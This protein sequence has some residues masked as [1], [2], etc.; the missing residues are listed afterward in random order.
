MTWADD[1]YPASKNTLRSGAFRR[2]SHVCARKWDSRLVRAHISGTFYTY[3][4]SYGVDSRSTGLVNSIKRFY[5]LVA[6]LAEDLCR[7]CMVN[8]EADTYRRRSSDER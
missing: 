6:V 3:L 7:C 8:P 1:L 5:S 2:R 4:P